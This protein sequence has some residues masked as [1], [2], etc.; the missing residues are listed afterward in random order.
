MSEDDRNEMLKLCL[1][2]YLMM[3]EN[4]FPLENARF[5]A[6]RDYELSQDEK[7][8][9]MVQMLKIIEDKVG[10]LEVTK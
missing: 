10:T 6:F 4:S 8:I 7:D 2:D 5:L 3:I 1:S 9:L